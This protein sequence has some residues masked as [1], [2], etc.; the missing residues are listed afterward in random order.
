MEQLLGFETAA[1]EIE[2][3]QLPL[4]MAIYGLGF[5]AVQ[6]VFFLLYLRAYVLRGA[7]GLDAHERSITREEIQGFI[8]G[9]GVGLTSIAVAF[10]G[11][12]EAASLAG[13]VYLLLFP[14][15]IGNSY[16]MKQCRKKNEAA[17]DPKE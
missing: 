10:L 11:G 6:L 16:L 9:M 13:Y 1:E 8:L 15:L 14:L 12:Q 4:L 17:A 7:L 5:V 3:E 2:P